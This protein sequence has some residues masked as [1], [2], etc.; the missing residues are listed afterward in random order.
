[1]SALLLAPVWS[2]EWKIALIVLLGIAVIICALL[3][4]YAV[5]M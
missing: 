3:I 4:E 5:V 1:M 2:I